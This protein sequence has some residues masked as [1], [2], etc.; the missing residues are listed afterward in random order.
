MKHNVLSNLSNEEMRELDK[1]LL[2]EEGLIK[3]VPAKVLEGI[4]QEKLS[5]WCHYNA[6]YGLHTTE[7]L[8]WIASYIKPGKTI[9]IGAGKGTLGKYLGIPQTDS[10]LSVK[11][12]EVKL[13]YLLMQQQVIQPHKYVLE[14]DA[15]EAVKH[16]KPEVVIGSWIT[17]QADQQI[18]QSNYWGV[19]EEE[20][21]KL[22]KT[23]IVIGNESS[24]GLKEILKYEH[25]KFSFDWLYSR[26]LG[27]EKNMIYIWEK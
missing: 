3:I 20:I 5:V 26:S 24:H 11:N 6:I 25:K 15:L 13:Y 21:L 4:P 8:E 22:V 23:Y 9:E 7:L 27:K 12:E 18:P 2:D 19:K 16:F 1:I 17:Q 14:Y 10:Y